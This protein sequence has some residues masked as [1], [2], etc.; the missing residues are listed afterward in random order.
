MWK[1]A[2]VVGPFSGRSTA[3]VRRAAMIKSKLIQRISAQNPHLYQRDIEKIVH[4]ILDALTSAMARGDRIE[5][6]ASA[7]SE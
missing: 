6:R 1:L 2:L 4:V 3:K 5:L 7:V